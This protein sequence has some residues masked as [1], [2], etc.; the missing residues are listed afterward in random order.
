MRKLILAGR[1]VTTE[2][3]AFVMGI[4]NVTPDS[5]WKESRGGAE[6]A[7]QLIEEGADVLDIGGES[8]RPGAEYVSA[9]EEIAR[10]T[11][12]IRSIRKKS[13]IPISIDTRKKKVME[14]AVSEGA[15]IL[16]DISALEDDDGLGSYAASVKIPVILMHKR[17]IPAIMQANTAYENVFAEV[18][19]YL[20]QRAS[21]ALS[22]GIPADRLIIDPGI[23]FGKNLAANVELIRNCGKLCGGAYPVLM[24]LSRKTCI[25]EMTGQPVEKRLYG[26]LAA[27]ILSVQNGA[28]MIRVHD[29]AAAV[30]TMKVMKYLEGAKN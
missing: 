12:V 4:V 1:T 25:G 15:D 17:G 13:S 8:S 24:A 26:T 14:A 30:D 5:F 27:D 16:N 6:H 7:M 11:P 9:E 3:P 23:G 29:A 19:S 21:Y 22:C 28:F 10:I 2:N 20:R 18:D